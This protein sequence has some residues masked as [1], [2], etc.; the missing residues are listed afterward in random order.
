MAIANVLAEL[1]PAITQQQGQRIVQA[2]VTTMGPPPEGVNNGPFVEACLRKFIKS[3]VKGAD[4]RTVEETLSTTNAAT[5]AEFG[6]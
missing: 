6:D 5:D 3:V 2:F 1:W 4:R